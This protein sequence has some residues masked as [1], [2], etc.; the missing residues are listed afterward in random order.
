MRKC[1]SSLDA[2]VFSC[3]SCTKNLDSIS[4]IIEEH[5][6]E[7]N[8]EGFE[9]DS[10]AKKEFENPGCDQSQDK[11]ISENVPPNNMLVQEKG[12]NSIEQTEKNSTRKKGRKFG[13]GKTVSLDDF[14]EKVNIS[15]QTYKCKKCDTEDWFQCVCQGNLL[16]GH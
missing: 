15:D 10:I 3:A 9:T 6:D 8:I 12:S 16:T 1:L 2:Y 7:K 14:L 5:F 11:S 4:G 13:K